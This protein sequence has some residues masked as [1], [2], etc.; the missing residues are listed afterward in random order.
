MAGTVLDSPVPPLPHRP[1]NAPT[2]VPGRE[3]GGCTV[4][5]IVLNI[6]SPG[7]QKPAGMVCPNCTGA[8]CAIHASRPQ[9]CRAYHCLWRSSENLGP[10]WRPDLSGVLVELDEADI[11]PGY[12]TPAVKFSPLRGADT[13]AWKPLLTAIASHM[14]RGRAVFLG[15]KAPAGLTSR[16]V[17]L[18][19][20]MGTAITARNLAAAHAALLEAWASA[21]ED[22]RTEAAQKT[23]H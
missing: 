3:C 23:R 10:D 9:V 7:L 5:C 19:E 20:R 16:K 8:G 21:Q 13:L 18:N 4:C 17:F 22:F 2:L 11:P 6:D 1:M 12:G 14:Q 15:A